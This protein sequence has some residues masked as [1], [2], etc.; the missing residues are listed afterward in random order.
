MPA[1]SVRM[2]AIPVG[3]RMRPGRRQRSGAIRPVSSQAPEASQGTGRRPDATPLRHASIIVSL[4]LLAHRAS[5]APK[6]NL[7]GS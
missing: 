3:C 1:P 7:N 6:V 4:P 5:D 2:P